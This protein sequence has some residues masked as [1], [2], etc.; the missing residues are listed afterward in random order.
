[1]LRS[2]GFFFFSTRYYM[3]TLPVIVRPMEVTVCNCV[4]HASIRGYFLSFFPN[5][6]KAPL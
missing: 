4:R 5:P 3:D 2:F 1:M 6:R